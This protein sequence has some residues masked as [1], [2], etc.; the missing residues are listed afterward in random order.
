M[1]RDLKPQKHIKKS[2]S[3]N[4]NSISNKEESNGEVEK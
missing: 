4:N 3:S 2:I 1:Q